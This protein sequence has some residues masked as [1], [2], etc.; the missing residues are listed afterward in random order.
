MEEGYGDIAHSVERSDVGR[1]IREGQ[2]GGGGNT[3]D[4]NWGG[5]DGAGSE[6]RLS[7]ELERGFRDSSDEEDDRR[8]RRGRR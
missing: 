3:V 2:R 8:L 1:S 5:D 6:R 7:R 4:G